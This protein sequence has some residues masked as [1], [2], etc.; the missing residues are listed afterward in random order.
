VFTLEGKISPSSGPREGWKQ[1]GAKRTGRRSHAA[2]WEQ[3]TDHVFLY[4]NQPLS[5]D[6]VRGRIKAAGLRVGVKVY[7]HCLC[8]TCA[9]QLLNAGCRVTSL[10]KFLGHKT[11]KATMVYAKVHAHTVADDYFAAMEVVEQRL[12]V[13]ASD[14]ASPL[15]PRGAPPEVTTPAEP[16]PEPERQALLVIAEQLAEP[17]LPESVR[18]ALVTQLLMVL[19]PQ[20]VAVPVAREP[21]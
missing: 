11:L 9:T 19:A 14:E 17:E 21:P 6:L 3:E 4:R 20:R 16:V 1:K 7:P 2:A 12:D 13:S 5:K 15:N 8:H 18:L 10:Q